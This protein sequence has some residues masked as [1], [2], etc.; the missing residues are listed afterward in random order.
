[1][2]LSCHPD[3]PALSRPVL[4]AS[5]PP[6][7]STFF[8]PTTPH[9]RRTAAP[10]KPAPAPLHLTRPF[11]CTSQD[12]FAA[13]HKTLLLHL[14]KP[15]RYTRQDP[16]AAPHN[17]GPSQGCCTLSLSYTSTPCLPFA[18][19]RLASPPEAGK[20]PRSPHPG[21]PDGTQPPPQKQL[22]DAHAH[23]HPRCNP[24]AANS[25]NAI[26]PFRCTPH[27]LTPP[28]PRNHDACD[29]P[30]NPGMP[31]NVWPL[32]SRGRPKFSS[33]SRITLSALRLRR[34]GNGAFASASPTPG[35][36]C[37]L[38][39]SPVCE[40]GKGNDLRTGQPSLPSALAPLPT[41][42]EPHSR[43]A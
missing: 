24:R 33:R 19:P 11:C 18:A 17:A 4:P 5:G 42:A 1:M 3:P 21:A 8:R 9:P 31:V 43:Q 40:P 32:G 6:S 13:P 10:D 26:L 22:A 15:F 27:T 20:P 12:P 30:P 35:S 41:A 39:P 38:G 25:S 28:G 23:N 34:Y 36:M 29:L 37:P 7:A 14:T 16:F 2:L